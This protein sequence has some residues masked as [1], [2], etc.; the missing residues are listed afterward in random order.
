MKMKKRTLVE[1][2]DD[3][4]LEKLHIVLLM[5]LDDFSRICKE[6]DICWIGMY[7]TA[8]GALRHKGFI[9][10]DDDVDICMPR[11]DHDRFCKIVQEQYSDKYEIVN[12]LTCPNYPMTTTRF[13]LKG[14]E[15]RDA[16]L[17]TMEFDSGIFLDL[18]PLDYLADDEKDFKKQAWRCW[19]YNKL[20]IARDVAHPYIADNGIKSKLLRAGTIC[21]H[22]LLNLP[23]INTINWAKMSL[24]W[25]EKY[26]DTQTQRMGY[27]CDTNRFTCIYNVDDLLPVKYV[28]FEDIE[29][30]VAHHAEKLLSDYYGNWMEKPPVSM[31]K[32]HYPNILDFGPYD[33]DNTYV[34]DEAHE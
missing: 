24:T 26:K 29:I 6:N 22:G 13:I 15:F 3:P 19:L 18:F 27:L 11:E 30:P 14:T 4:K 1:E 21:A 20:A 31:R 34:K 17:A 8:I 5:M 12:P 25:S 7:G 2:H 28:P 16:N 9:P 33:P 23:G 10:W 32:E